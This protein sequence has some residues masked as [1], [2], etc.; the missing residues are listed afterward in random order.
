MGELQAGRKVG[1]WVWYIFPQLEGLGRSATAQRFALADADEAW[2]F[3]SH[4]LLG[5]RLA[6]A[7]DTVDRHPGTLHQLM[8]DPLDAKKLVSSLTL[9]SFVRQ[10]HQ[11]D[12]D[13][14][15]AERALAVAMA[16][17]RT[18]QKAAAEGIPKCAFTLAALPKTATCGAWGVEP[19]P[20]VVGSAVAAV[21]YPRCLA[22][23]LGNVEAEWVWRLSCQAAAE[24]GLPDMTPFKTV[25]NGELLGWNEWLERNPLGPID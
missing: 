15:L 6:L 2:A 10:V 14:L 11:F 13:K 4:P 16:C 7:I 3:V 5:A 18:L 21:S 8:A 25:V 19:A 24:P 1:H 20:L 22:C 9:F 17:H 23:Q 12:H